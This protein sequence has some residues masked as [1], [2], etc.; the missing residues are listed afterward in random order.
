MGL[1]VH[2]NASAILLLPFLQLQRH[3]VAWRPPPLRGAP[4][5]QRRTTDVGRL[6]QKE[7]GWTV[8]W[9][10]CPAP[11][12]ICDPL[13]QGCNKRPETKARGLHGM[14]EWNTIIEG[15]LSCQYS[16]PKQVNEHCYDCGKL[17]C[18]DHGDDCRLCPPQSDT[19]VLI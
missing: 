6:Q 3:G 10:H 12:S 5:C 7:A 4:C 2:E 15:L 19:A 1:E 16:M 9:I 8:Y 14:L 13:S 18:A 11:C 17:A